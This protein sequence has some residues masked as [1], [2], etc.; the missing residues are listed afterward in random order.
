MTKKISAKAPIATRTATAK[1]AAAAKASAI[2]DTWRK[3]HRDVLMTA[4]RFGQ[5]LTILECK[6]RNSKQLTKNLQRA[7]STLSLFVQD[8]VQTGIT[9]SLQA[10]L[11]NAR[12]TPV[13]NG[14]CASQIRFEYGTRQEL[15]DLGIALDSLFE[16]IPTPPGGQPAIATA[17]ARLIR[18]VDVTQTSL[19]EFIN[20]PSYS[21]AA[22]KSI[23]DVFA[24]KQSRHGLALVEVHLQALGLEEKVK[25]PKLIDCLLEQRTGQ[26]T[27]IPWGVKALSSVVDCPDLTVRRELTNQVHQSILNVIFP[28]P[29]DS[30]LEAA[31]KDFLTGQVAELNKAK[32]NLELKAAAA[33]ELLKAAEQKKVA[34][35]LKSLPKEVV[36]ALQRNPDLVKSL[37][38]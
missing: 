23:Q 5:V 30:T 34:D 31:A 11:N 25:E 36:K 18:N 22:Q 32:A 6:L 10:V 3:I 14:L 16:G 27:A 9:S 8:A 4:V 15:I 24:S 13:W 38:V 29:S 21:V 7:Q 33:R 35:A 2:P 37:R 20:M 1:A 19:A 26:F 28:I 12:A 17:F